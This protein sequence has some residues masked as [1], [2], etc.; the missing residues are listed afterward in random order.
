MKQN[1]QQ[2]LFTLLTAQQGHFCFESGHHGTVWFDLNALFLKPYH[3]ERLISAL[4]KLLSRHNLSAI[5]GPLEGG[6]F[7]AQ[8]IATVLQI[9]FYYTERVV[10][11]TPEG[12][13]SV[14]Y[15]LPK[16]LHHHVQD[17][18]VAV[19]DDVINAGSAVQATFNELQL[20]GA[21]PVAVGAFLLLG[22]TMTTFCTEHTIPL[23][24]LAHQPNDLWEPSVCPL[25]AANIPLSEPLNIKSPES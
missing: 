25:C 16:L 23:T 24:Y 15:R 3:L 2:E 13:Y 11:S 8:T 17:K 10:P 22:D 7:L 19:V 6:A 1:H 21:N 4:A 18:R 20:H 12:I 14:Q 9:E 5:C